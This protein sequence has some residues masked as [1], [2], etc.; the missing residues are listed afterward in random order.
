MKM[1]IVFLCMH[2]LAACAIWPA[3]KTCGEMVASDIATDALPRV[4]AI[5]ANPD[6]GVV[7]TELLDMA[8]KHGIEFVR[9]MVE[10][11]RGESSA[12]PGS[13]VESA[14][15]FNNADRWLKETR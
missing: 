1:L 2:A 6:F 7:K 12:A 14:T 5:L 9:C 10:Q 13:T 11:I 8:T 4:R 15:R 3:A